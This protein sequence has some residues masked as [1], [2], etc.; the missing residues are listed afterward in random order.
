MSVE[1]PFLSEIVTNGICNAAMEIVCFDIV[2]Y[3]QR[4]SA[5]QRRIIDQFTSILRQAFEA[6]DLE[7]RPDLKKL[8]REYP[9]D[10]VVASTGDGALVGLPIVTSASLIFALAVMDLLEK[11]NGEEARRQKSRVGDDR[12][13]LRC[14]ITFGEA[15]IYK[16]VNN[17]YNMAGDCVNMAA[18]ICDKAKPQSI[19]L[20][21]GAVS[22]LLD[23][24]DHHYSNADFHSLGEVV[25]KHGRKEQVRQYIRDGHTGI[26]SVPGLREESIAPVVEVASFNPVRKPE[27]P[28]QALTPLGRLEARLV[29]VAPGDYQMGDA[30]YGRVRVTFSA[31]FQID[32][33]CVTQELYEFVMGP[34]ANLSFFKGHPRRPVERVSWKDAIEFCNALSLLCGEAPVYQIGKK[35]TADFAKSGFRLPTEAEW[36][37]CCLSGGDDGSGPLDEHAWHARNAG[38]QTHDVGSRAPNA[39][40]LFDML[41]NV[42]EWCHDWFAQTFPNRPCCDFAGPDNGATRVLRGGSWRD[43]PQVVDGR[44]RFDSGSLVRES[45]NGFRLLRRPSM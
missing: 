9:R 43:Q 20:S 29:T 18:R 34:D 27:I 41:G 17:N 10:L 15:I 3:S 45:T 32:R 38:G 39:L 11:F 8:S 16:D 26:D 42:R 44:F 30:R 23:Q 21:E 22:R 28:A 13:Q 4:S 2:S 5:C 7:F 12:F 35:V 36:E 14:G 6:V 1:S 37:F 33:E 19:L 25:F 24:L 31:P 40:G